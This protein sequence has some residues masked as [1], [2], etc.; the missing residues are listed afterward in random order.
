MMSYR[1]NL[2][3]ALAPLTTVKEMELGIFA[4]YT[5]TQDPQYL[6]QLRSI[7]TK[8]ETAASSSARL[9]VPSDAASLHAGVLNA[10]GEFGATLEALADN[11]SDPI[12][13]VALLR[14]YRDAEDNMIAS[15]NALAMYY[16]HHPKT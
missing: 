3:D 9:T 2:K 10:M 15:F 7:A 6:D 5:Q 11:A 14:T 12:T 4:H 1:N 16:S 8:Y 13:V